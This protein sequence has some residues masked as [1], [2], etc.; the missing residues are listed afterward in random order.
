MYPCTHVCACACWLPVACLQP[1]H[2]QAAC[3]RRL[4]C[5]INPPANSAFHSPSPAVGL[6]ATAAA[7]DTAPN[8][9]AAA[10]PPIDDAAVRGLNVPV[11]VLPGAVRSGAQSAGAGAGAWAAAGAAVL[12]AAAQLL[13]AV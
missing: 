9:T 8:V 7:N 1:A 10:G 2:V 13:A 6:S 12:L 11:V 3:C 5:C 4:L